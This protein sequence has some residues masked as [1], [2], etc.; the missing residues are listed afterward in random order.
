MTKIAI[1]LTGQLRT[2]N[3]VKYL[4]MNT[5]IS[6]Y[7]ADVFMGV[8]IDN[9]LQSE[10]KNSKNTTSLK[11]VQEVINFFKPVDYF[12]MKNF[13]D[14]FIKLEKNCNFSLSCYK[15]LFQQYFVAAGLLFVLAEI[16]GIIEEI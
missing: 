14:E 10:N 11:D 12:I 1:L 16:L 5:L 6:K 13:N 7:N 2:V 9:S 8:D 4:H 3:L 15:I